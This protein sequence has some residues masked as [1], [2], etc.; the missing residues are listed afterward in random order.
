MSLPVEWR[1]IQRRSRSIGA[2][3]P[4]IVFTTKFPKAWLSLFSA[5][6]FVSQN[7]T[8]RPDCTGPASCTNFYHTIR[9]VPHDSKVEDPSNERSGSVEAP[10]G[11]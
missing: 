8:L 2:V 10:E 6:E 5:A 4:W 1:D 11:R 7:L 9:D 3:H